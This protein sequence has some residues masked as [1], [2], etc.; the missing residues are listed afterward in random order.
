[1]SK[2]QFSFPKVERF[3]AERK[4]LNEKISYDISPAVSKRS[5]GFGYGHKSDFTK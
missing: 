1:V 5:A 3:K 2:Q 4:S